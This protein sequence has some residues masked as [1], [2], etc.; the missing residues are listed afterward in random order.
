MPRRSLTLFALFLAAAP[1]AQALDVRVLSHKSNLKTETWEE[2]P[3]YTFASL[4]FPPEL[5]REL[6]RRTLQ[7]FYDQQHGRSFRHL[8]DTRD[9]NHAHFVRDASGLRALLLHTQERA[10]EA[11]PGSEYA[12]LDMDAR[13]WLVRLDAPERFSNAL[14][15]RHARKPRDW[16]AR[17]ERNV[18]WWEYEEKKTVTVMMLDPEKTGIEAVPYLDSE[19][20]EQI[21]FDRAECPN[22][23]EDALERSNVLPIEADGGRVCLYVR[24]FKCLFPVHFRCTGVRLR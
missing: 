22:T 14:S 3:V 21:N 17:W 24:D 2:Q 10:G 19:K 23:T 11:L 9:F 4:G 1:A 18:P 6:L 16:P 12:A 15:L 7:A 8:G 5:S 13:N 20:G